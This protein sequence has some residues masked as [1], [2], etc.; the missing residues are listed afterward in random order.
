MQQSN[1]QATY[2]KSCT[3]QVLFSLIG[4]IQHLDNR[5]VSDVP[6]RSLKMHPIKRKIYAS[7]QISLL[8][9]KHTNKQ[10]SKQTNE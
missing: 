10:T 6:N 7:T 2:A 1:D 9:S 8:A 4:I 3:N 5:W